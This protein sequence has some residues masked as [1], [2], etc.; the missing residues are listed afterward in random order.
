MNMKSLQASQPHSGPPLRFIK[1]AGAVVFHRGAEIEYLLIRAGYWEFPKG[2][3]DADESE[4][5][6]ALREVREETG[7]S[8]Q[9]IGDV[10]RRLEYFFRLREN[11]A[12]VKKTVAYFI[13]QAATREVQLS[14]EHQAAQWVCFERAMELL[15]YENTREILRWAHDLIRTPELP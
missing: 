11:G 3:V 6:A 1:S 13:G 14:R 10:C 7:L 5:D 2:M 9:L 15:P 4:H 8:V 12:L